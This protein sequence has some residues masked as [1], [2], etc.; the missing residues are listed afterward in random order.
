[1]I[2]Q[3]QIS[4]CMATYNGASY[5][6]EQIASILPQLTGASELV[7]VDDASS[8]DTV[9]IVESLDDPR[10]RLISQPHNLGAVRTF[11]RAIRE[12]TGEVIFLSD[13][14]DVWHP[15]KVATMMKAFAADPETTLVLSNGEMIDAGGRPLSQRLY[16][17]DRFSSGVLANLVKNR[18]QGSTMAFRREI[19]AAALPFPSG[20]PLH[21]SWIALVNAVIG[22][23]VFLP[24]SLLFYRRHDTNATTARHGTILRMASQRWRLGSSLLLR[25]KTMIHV[26][27]NLHSRERAISYAD[28]ADS[29]QETICS[30]RA[31][32]F[33]P[34]FSPDVPA[35]RPR[36]AQSMLAEI[37]HRPLVF[38]GMPVYNCAGT[39]AQAIT[40]I[41]NQ[42]FV[43]WE[44]LIIDD[45][46]TDNTIDIVEAFHDP[47]I[48]LIKG[49]GTKGLTDR[50]NEC[51]GR[52]TGRFF[53]R[54][55]G[56]DIA[57]PERLRKQVEY[58]ES[59]PEVDLLSAACI[60][61]K[62][63]GDAYG[64]R[65]AVTSHKEI[66]GNALSGLHLLHSN[67][68]GRIE[69][70]LRNPYRRF[71]KR[72][73]DRELL[74]RARNVSHFAA[75][76][77]VLLGVREERVQLRKMLPA[78]IYLCCAYMEDA[79]LRGHELYGLGGV[80]FQFLKAILDI[81]AVG[82]NLQHK[83]L[84]HRAR[85]LP[86]DVRQEWNEVWRQNSLLQTQALPQ[87][88]TEF[89]LTEAFKG[90]E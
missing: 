17:Q 57:Y 54:M 61:F 65:R 51:V 83:L 12:A 67:W 69:W 35:S 84:R 77:D 24:E 18:Y 82:T 28:I 49:E 38:I 55:D 36:F 33:S 72:S 56:D 48:V 39:V 19:L 60:V 20:I 26:K 40:S 5:I 41:L 15:D 14:D 50:L 6:S 23:A 81:I 80:F 79:F 1:M 43:D 42:T 88:G 27:Q 85:F 73:Q 7:I 2:G 21:D 10:I 32:V 31:V 47:R 76:P 13:Q 8:D 66:C 90:Q 53:A 58:L 87:P 78:R 45:G 62:G 89:G 64:L 34:F 68:M 4:V 44:L 86:D 25:L 37:T 74:M 71:F 29:H 75:L 22:R 59:Q 70:F 30:R 52:A 46:S 3:R 11:E 9:A 63:N 16:K